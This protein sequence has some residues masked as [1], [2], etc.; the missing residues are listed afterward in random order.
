MLELRQQPAWRSGSR[1]M[2]ILHTSTRLP[3]RRSKG[4]REEE[5]KEDQRKGKNERE[6]DIQERI[7]R[8]QSNTR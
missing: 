8:K 6:K 5:G 4:I 3:R 1:R 2:L 7:H